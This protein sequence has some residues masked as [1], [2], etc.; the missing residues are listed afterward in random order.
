[1]D[2]HSIFKVTIAR[3]RWRKGRIYLKRSRGHSGTLG[4][5][6]ADRPA[7]EE[8]RSPQSQKTNTYPPLMQINLGATLAK[9]EQYDFYR[10]LRDKEMPQRR[11]TD[12]N[13]EAIQD[14]L[15]ETSNKRPTTKRV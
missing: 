13:V 6:E 2:R 3:I 15:Q 14:A 4:N 1:M 8:A 10:I 5:E 11:T 9:M 7:G 12:Q